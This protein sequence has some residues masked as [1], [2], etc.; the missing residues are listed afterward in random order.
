MRPIRILVA[1]LCLL[2]GVMVGALNPQMVEVDLGLAMLR[3]TLGLALLAC[4]L[5]GAI[6]GGLAI[7]VSV[8][9]PLRQRRRLD[10]ARP[11][12]TDAN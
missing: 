12:D 9:L 11:R 5:L 1:M 10:A 7:M 3:P 6:A 4:L 2:A 8:L